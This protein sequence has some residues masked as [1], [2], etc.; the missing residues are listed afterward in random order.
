MFYKDKFLCILAEK[1]LSQAAAA[2]AIGITPRGFFNKLQSGRFYASEI[3]CMMALLGIQSPVG[4]FLSKPDKDVPHG[5]VRK[6]S[7]CLAMVIPSNPPLQYDKAGPAMQIHR[8]VHLDPA[9]PDAEMTV[10]VGLSE[11]GI[12]G[13]SVG[14]A[15]LEVRLI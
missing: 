14:T 3:E 1:G 9:L 15:G 12:E 7:A 11:R 10:T 4:I 2:R 13:L 8:L 5:A 6:G